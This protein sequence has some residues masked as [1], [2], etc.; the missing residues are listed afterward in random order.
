MLLCSFKNKKEEN[1]D[2]KKVV[3]LSAIGQV[4]YDKLSMESKCN[5]PKAS[6]KTIEE[7]RKNHSFK[8][9]EAH[10][11]TVYNTSSFQNFLT[12]LFEIEYIENIIINGNSQ[13]DR[14]NQVFIKKSGNGQGERV[15]HCKFNTTKGASGML[16]MDIYLTENSEEKIDNALINIKEKLIK[17]GIIIAY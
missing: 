6:T 5:L 16:D 10:A 14:G 11:Q 7:K 2:K 1:I 8:G 3:S 17:Q 4:F 13:T 12:K 15:L 9:N